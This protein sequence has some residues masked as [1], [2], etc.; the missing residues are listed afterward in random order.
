M[1]GHKALFI[2]PSAVYYQFRDKTLYAGV[3]YLAAVLEKIG[4]E[5]EIIDCRIQKGF[6]QKIIERLKNYSV[7]CLSVNVATISSALDLANLI[8]DQSPKA[9]I[10]MGGP[11]PSVLYEKLIPKY[12]DIVVIGEGEETIVELFQSGSLSK[13]FGIAYWDDCVKVTPP[14]VFNDNLDA[15]PY[16]AWH[17]FDL[18]KYNFGG[19][20]RA[21]YAPLITSRGCPWQ[22]IYCTKLVHGTKIRLRSIDNVVEEIDYLK[23]RFDVKD[24][25]IVDDNFTFY[26]ERVKEFCNKIIAKRYK[27]IRFS[28]NNGIRADICDPEMFRLLKKIGCYEVLIAVES[29]SQ[30]IQE[31]LGKKLDLSKVRKTVEEVRKT[32]MNARL[33]FILGLPFDTKESMQET[34]NFSKSIPM[35]QA[36]FFV[37]IPFPGTKFYEFVEKNG[38]FLCDLTYNS[39]SYSGKAVYELDQLK[40]KDV[41]KF[42]KRSYREFYLRPGQIFR[43][44]KKSN[45]TSLRGLFQSVGYYLRRLFFSL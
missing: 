8:R 33:S 26:P 40:A 17:L 29:A 39:V 38:K 13:V 1:M 45:I 20:V 11:H 9:K 44:L 14:R 10:I 36:F 24:I 41:E 4:V 43:N 42:Y 21:T 37:A 12:A 18:K 5:V 32:G 2:I 25:K 7:I 30:E 31:K 22:C 3:A 28:L 19:N 27:N 35:E 15:L 16:P 6:K 23:N 34:I